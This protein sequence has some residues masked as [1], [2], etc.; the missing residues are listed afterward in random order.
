MGTN[1]RTNS[2][3]TYA[4]DRIK[5]WRL[6]EAKIR[7]L[8]RHERN[9]VQEL[10]HALCTINKDTLTTAVD[11]GHI[12]DGSIVVVVPF[13]RLKPTNGNIKLLRRLLRESSEFQRLK[14]LAKEQGLTKLTPIVRESSM[15]GLYSVVILFFKLPEKLPK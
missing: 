14:K 5:D 6:K 15:S 10:E 7:A 4:L 12:E 2:V 1:I 9:I 8:N 11:D 13:S 3:A